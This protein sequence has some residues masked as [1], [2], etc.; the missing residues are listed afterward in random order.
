MAKVLRDI[1]IEFDGE[2]YVFT[3]SNRLL[4]RI[5]AGLSP[6]S[7]MGVCNTMS[8]EQLPLYD[9]AYIVSEFIKAGGGD[10]DEEDVLVEL[11]DDLANNEGRG[12]GPLIEALAAALSPPTSAAK[13][14]QAPAQTGASKRKGKRKV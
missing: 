8:N 10:V 9:I 14:R 2:T 3:P 12:L 11:Q 4:R 5:D 1:S 13:N 7:L 6:N